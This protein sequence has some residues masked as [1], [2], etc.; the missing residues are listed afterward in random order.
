MLDFVG[1]LSAGNEEMVSRAQYFRKQALIKGKQARFAWK[2][3]AEWQRRA[4]WNGEGK[5]EEE[6]NAHFP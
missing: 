6:E 3:F 1:L 5:K 2:A 4:R